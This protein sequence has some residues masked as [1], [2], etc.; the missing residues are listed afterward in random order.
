MS[1][2]GLAGAA[3]SEG[4]TQLLAQCGLPDRPGEGNREKCHAL[5]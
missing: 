2:G 3:G 1:K 4:R 5:G